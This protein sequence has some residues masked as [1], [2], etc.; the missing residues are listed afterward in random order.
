MPSFKAAYPP[1]GSAAWGPE[2]LPKYEGGVVVAGYQPNA[3]NFDGVVRILGNGFDVAS[4]EDNFVFSCWLKP[5]AAIDGQN[6]EILNGN[7]LTLDIEKTSANIIRC[8]AWN[9]SS[10]LIVDMSSSTPITSSGGWQHIYIHR[11]G[12][13]AQIM[14][15]GVDDTA[16]SPTILAGTAKFAN[17][18]LWGFGVNFSGGLRTWT[19][20]F[21]DPWFDNG[22]SLGASDVT[23]FYDSGPVDPGANGETPTGS[24]P[25]LYLGNPFGSFHT[26][27]GTDGDFGVFGG[28]TLSACADAPS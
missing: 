8:R 28:S 12:T 24:S 26:N 27:L 2:G 10:S 21:A 25:S 7:N 16:G 5:A 15:N 3:V 17:A 6:A 9:P 4:D 22:T 20:C 11:T 14:L 1:A 18:T 19:G 23:K 13:T